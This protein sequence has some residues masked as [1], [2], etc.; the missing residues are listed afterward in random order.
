M[1]REIF[2]KVGL[3]VCLLAA[4]VFETTSGPCLG[5][6]D[7]PA[8]KSGAP[9][10]QAESNRRIDPP[11]EI[12]PFFSP[13]PELSGDFGDYRS[14]LKF[15]DGSDVKTPA[16]WQR[17][18]QEILNTWHKIMGQWP[19]LIEKPNVEILEKERRENF[20]QH[21][22]R[23]E[24]APDYPKMNGYLLVP[25]GK[26]P[27]PAVIVV[28]YDAET[29]IGLGRELRDFA[30]QLAKRGFVALSVGTPSS[31]YYPTAENAQLQPLSAMAYAAANCYNAV[32]N[33]PEVDPR[34]VGIVGHSYGGKWAMFASCLYEKFACAAWSDGGVVFDE[35]RPNVNYWEPWYLGYESGKKRA[36]GVPT[37]ENPRTGAYKRLLGEGHDLHELHAL[38]APRPF[39]VSGGSEDQSERWK[40][41]NHAVAVNAF[42]G[43]AN[44]VAMT[45]RRDHTPTTESNEQLYLFFEHFL[46][47]SRPGEESDAAK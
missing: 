26:G 37:S 7:P 2:G 18:R 44:R 36:A 38:M 41:L 42:L 23:V 46:K 40:A 32:A 15:Y 35:S 28:Y 31:I 14:P 33:L 8:Q 21:H 39:L 12:A 30:Y 22:V 11:G 45:N 3:A 34:R 24:V 16:D 4:M 25:D 10:E 20:T 5:Q 6:A 27:F 29:G 47:R 13:P 43:Y 1:E 19:R 9:S 17:R